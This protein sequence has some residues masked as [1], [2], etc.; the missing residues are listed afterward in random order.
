VTR[1]YHRRFG[2]TG[3]IVALGDGRAFTAA[4]CIAAVDGRPGTSIDASGQRFVVVRRWSPART[5]LAV[6]RAVDARR[7]RRPATTR[8]AVHGG[9][10]RGIEVTFVGHV[11]GRRFERRRAVVTSV[12]ASTAVA[13]VTHPRGVC[14]NDSGGPVFLGNTLVGIVT[15]RA[16]ALRRSPCS[17]QVIFTRLDSPTMR[18][19][20]AKAFAAARTT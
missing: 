2:G 19:R 14:G 13:L 18:A 15:H 17:S 20:I 10:R 3:T 11:D 12:T 6:L 8:L 5:D 1:R 16:G 9:V 4:H 7:P